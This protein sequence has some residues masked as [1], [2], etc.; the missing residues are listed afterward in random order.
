MLGLRK[1]SVVSTKYLTIFGNKLRKHERY[2]VLPTQHKYENS[3]PKSPSLVQ[4]LPG[5]AGQRESLLVCSAQQQRH[6]RK[7][8]HDWW[9]QSFFCRL[10]WFPNQS[11]MHSMAGVH[12]TTWRHLCTW[13]NMWPTRSWLV[14]HFDLGSVLDFYN[15]SKSGQLTLQISIRWLSPSLCTSWT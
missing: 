13:L 5:S 7:P 1:L 9:T 12:L 3:L 15:C 10:V 8:A 14:L 2:P 6:A 11:V 4:D